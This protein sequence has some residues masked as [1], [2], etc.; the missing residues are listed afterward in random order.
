MQIR[1]GFI[2]D[3]NTKLIS[4]NI[5]FLMIQM[6]QVRSEDNVVDLFSKS[7]SKSTFEK[8]IKSIGLRKVS[9]L[10]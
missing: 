9:D 2:N 1:Q 4:N 5:E 8:H 10:P 6:N 7:L 3:D